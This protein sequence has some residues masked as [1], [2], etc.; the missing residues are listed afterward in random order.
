MQAIHEAPRLHLSPN[1]FWAFLSGL[2]L[3]L[4][5]FTL[6]G[7]AVGPGTS[8]IDTVVQT[9]AIQVGGQSLPAGAASQGSPLFAASWLHAYVAVYLVLMLIFLGVGA[10]CFLLGVS[11]RVLAYAA[12]GTIPGLAYQVVT[13][14]SVAHHV[15]PPFGQVTFLAYSALAFGLM[16]LLLLFR[17]QS[18]VLWG[19]L[20]GNAIHIALLLLG[21]MA[22]QNVTLFS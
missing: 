12:W 21:I 11:T 6:A 13:I 15:N 5:P 4:L 3:A 16:V 22:L 9:I 18:R 17:R 19:L 7:Q 10:W 2:W 8:L 14:L 20:A 1:G